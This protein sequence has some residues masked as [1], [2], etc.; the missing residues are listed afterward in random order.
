M[1]KKFLLLALILFCLVG[2]SGCPLIDDHDKAPEN[3]YREIHFALIPEECMEFKDNVCS[4]FTCMV[5]S[6]YCEEPE[7]ILVKENKNHYVIGNEKDVVR[8]VQEYLNSI[9]S[10]YKAENAVELNPVFYNVFAFDSERNEKV[11]VIA[12]DGAILETTCNV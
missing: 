8:D 12:V 4:L 2:F 3:A 11:F 1:K 6:C 7:G 9:N 10:E 5:D